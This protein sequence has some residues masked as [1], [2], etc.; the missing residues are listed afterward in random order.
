M[1]GVPFTNVVRP[2]GEGP[3]ACPCCGH[4]TLSERGGYEICPVCCWE[5]DGQDEH[6]ATEV[7]G[8]PN[9]SLSLSAARANF[10]RIGAVEERMLRRV[11][12]PLPRELP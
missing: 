3:Y 12:P 7:R 5:D 8:G 6:D 10:M 1:D 11:R 2:P 9:Y 4:M